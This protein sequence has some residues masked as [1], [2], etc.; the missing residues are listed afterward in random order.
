MLTRIDDEPEFTY[1]EYFVPIFLAHFSSNSQVKFPLVNL[2]I[3]SWFN[4]SI[5]ALISS[6]LLYH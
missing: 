6:L 1:I 4:H 2:G 5:R 3:S